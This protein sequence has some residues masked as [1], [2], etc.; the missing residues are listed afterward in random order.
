METFFVLKD[1]IIK[2]HKKGDIT[3]E[4]KIAIYKDE[5]WNLTTLQNR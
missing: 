5:E 2:L 3:F 1:K 4:E